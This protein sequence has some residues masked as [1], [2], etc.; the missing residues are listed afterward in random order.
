VSSLAFGG[1][2]VDTAGRQLVLDEGFAYVTGTI[3]DSPVSDYSYLPQG[4]THVSV[5]PNGTDDAFLFRVKLR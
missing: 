4:D 5:R 2:S 3:S 1:Q